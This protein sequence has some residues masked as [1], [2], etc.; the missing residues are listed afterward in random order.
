MTPSSIMIPYYRA[1]LSRLERCR[2]LM[3]EARLMDNQNNYR[4]W[5]ES[6]NRH[7]EI[8]KEKLGIKK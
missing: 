4:V 2:T 3:R 6:V 7:E 5:L 1:E 8:V